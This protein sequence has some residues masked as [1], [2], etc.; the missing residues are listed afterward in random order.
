M[1][2]HAKSTRTRRRVPF[3]G[4]NLLKWCPACDGP[5]L[6][7]AS[8][9]ACGTPVTELQ[10]TPPGDLRL[11]FEYDATRLREVV[12]AQFGPGTGS[13]LFPTH[14]V[15]LLNK[16]GGLDLDYEVLVHGARYG[17]LR[18]DVRRGSSQFHPARAGA[19]VLYKYCAETGRLAD[20]L[21]PGFLEYTVETER[22]IVE[23]KSV[24]VPGI[25]RV[26]REVRP[27]DPCIVFSQNG[28]LGVGYFIVDA[29]TL[30]EYLAGGR[31]QVAKLREYGAPVP[32]SAIRA[33][34]DY[35]RLEVDQL[36]EMNRSGLE[37]LEAEACDFI[38]QVHGAHPALPVATAYS[39]GKDS[40]ATL[41]LVKKALADH[42]TPVAVFFADT[43]LEFPEVLQNVRDVVHWGGFE[44]AYF[45]RDAGE[46]FW[47]LAEA[48]GPPARDF[49]F[50]CH[51][52]KAEQINDI[53]REIAGIASTTSTASTQE[54]SITSK[55]GPAV[56]VF[57]GQR[58]Y[59]SFS[60]AK[61]NRVYINSYIP[62]QL[63]ATPI[64]DWRALD[65]W[66]Y[67]LWQ[68]RDDP[69]LPINPLYFQGHD[70][71]GCYLCPAQS[72][73]SWATTARTHPDLHARWVAFL[74]R[75]RREAGLPPEWVSLGLWRVKNPHGQ[76]QELLEE[77]DIQ[78][79]PRATRRPG[80]SA[81]DL[82]VIVSKG[83]SPCTSGEF[84]VQ[85][86]VNHPLELEALFPLLQTLAPRVDYEDED[87]VVVITGEGH[88]GFT[89]T[90]F[91]DGSL[92]LQTGDARFKATKFL[93]RVLGLVARGEYCQ[94]CDVCVE[95]CPRSALARDATGGF[96]VDQHLCLGWSCQKCTTHCPL[97]PLVKGQVVGRARGTSK[98]HKD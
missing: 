91:A 55:T 87:G 81:R 89:C 48:F 37:T 33:P 7:G 76:W 86:R 42:G 25:A 43:G 13:Y 24:L 80:S 8:C 27:G 61:E 74:E 95:A 50:C 9:P 71:L 21:P 5:L 93:L 72:L 66:L 97:F 78:L 1:V 35:P 68:A 26:G 12:D 28:F 38:Q 88:G 14:Q 41:V 67:L 64:K 63:A 82:R 17:N 49:R 45:E 57:L 23:G 60:R 58:R 73:A 32:S 20:Q 10:V 79:T 54:A 4:K 59:E 31:G 34:R 46:K 62:Q 22:Y 75:Y 77:E 70:R 96:V 94:Q 11:A 51:T 3:L 29:A 69:A 84:S 83:F 90:L 39:G 6:R 2:P 40:L 56:L 53:I 44:D 15:I 18:Y 30:A 85:A 92:F 36:L 65:L 47:D 19:E 98:K 52:L 16:V